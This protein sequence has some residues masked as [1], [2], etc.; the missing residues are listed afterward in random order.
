MFML[1]CSTR[2]K[3]NESTYMKVARCRSGHAE[4]GSPVMVHSTLGL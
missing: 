2:K 4:V 1:Q 3:W